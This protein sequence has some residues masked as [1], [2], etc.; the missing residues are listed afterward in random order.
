MTWQTEIN[1]NR[2]RGDTETDKYNHRTINAVSDIHMFP[3]K[4]KQ[5]QEAHSDAERHQ[6]LNIRGLEQSRR[7]DPKNIP[8]PTQRLRRVDNFG[9]WGKQR[10]INKSLPICKVQ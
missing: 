10:R 5:Q 2:S 7:R 3:G 6:I 8:G 4:S 9:R 1:P